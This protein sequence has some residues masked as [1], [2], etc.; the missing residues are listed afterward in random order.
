[1]AQG[2]L[3]VGIDS[4]SAEADGEGNA[5]YC[6]NLIAALFAAPGDES[7]ALL[8][9]DPAHA[10]YTSL[11]ER[12]RSAVVG[13]RQGAGLLR[14]ALTLRRAA[15]RQRVDCLHVQYA[16]PFGWRRPLVVTVHDLGFLHVPESFPAALRVALR[17]IVPRS[18][19]RATAVIT[20]SEFCRQDIAARYRVPLDKVAAV[21]LG[22]A[23]AFHPRPPAE[24]AAV[25][26]RYGLENGFLFSLGRLNRRKNLARLLLAYERLRAAG[27]TGAP[28]VI[29]GKPD[30]GAEDLLAR[31]KLAPRG[32]GVRFVGL[33]PDADLPHFYGGAACFVYP[34]L[35]E[36]F[37][38]PLAE[39]MACG[40]PVVGADRTALP[41]LVG[42]AGL[43]VDPESVDAIAEAVTRVLKDRDLAADLGRRGLER[44]R[45]SSWAAT[46]R[47]TLGIYRAAAAASR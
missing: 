22:T 37:G 33:I 44:S 28:L 31:A 18:V 1:V 14:V 16:A 7:Y 12:D 41:E 9:R 27:V 47:R 21:P 29:G 25:L 17:V 43:L 2:P 42:D 19:A 4:H 15:A 30:F 5:T 24:T 45:R 11:P 23:P 20:D 36:G 3:R 32:G 39:A 6:R 40:T 34:S 35:F 10:F 38:L 8:A 46:A 13:V 26:A